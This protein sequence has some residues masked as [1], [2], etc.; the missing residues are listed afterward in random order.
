MDKYLDLAEKQ[1]GRP[2]VVIFYVWEVYLNP[3][4]ETG[5]VEVKDTD[6]TYT[7]SEKEFINSR[8][9]LKGKG[10]AVTVLDAATRKADT[11]YLPRYADP[12]SKALWQPLWTELRSRM[13]RRGLDKA[14][15]LGVA[16]DMWPT[17]EEAAFFNDVTAGLP[18]TSCS[19]HAAWVLSSSPTGKGQLHG[20]AS[21][22]YTAVALDFQFTINPANG[23]TYGWKKPL[24]H[25]QFWRF[26]Y[27]NTSTQS[28]IRG[29]AEC[30]ITGNQ[31]GLAHIGG[32]FWFAIKNKSGRRAGTVSGRYPESY[33]HNLNIQGWLLGAGPTGPAATTRLEVFREGLQECEA[34][35][36]IENALTDTALKAKL[37]ADLARRAQAALDERQL[38]LWRAKGATDA[39]LQTGLVR[40]YRTYV[41]QM[42]KKWD[43]AAG[44]KWF[45]RSGWQ[46]HDAMLYTLA[47]EAA[48]ALSR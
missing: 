12:Q 38:A 17:K 45:L 15:M 25:G 42:Q 37:G 35:I 3:P 31:R 9:A 4:K 1:M 6:D 13:V 8:Q 10:P 46:E 47:G 39:D 27:F 2:K 7:R 36:F 21:V 24:L 40:E 43:A 28:T 5:T 14:L 11:F 48:R 41:Y 34:R 20:L 16:S 26:Q 18:W 29:E 33:W 19:H 44:H 22:G 32:D 30:N 23:R